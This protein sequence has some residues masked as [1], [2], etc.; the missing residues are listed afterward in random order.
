MWDLVSY[1]SKHNLLN[2]EN[3]QDGENNNHSYNHG[4]EGLTHNLQIL[5]LRKQQ[6]KN[7]LLIL[8]ISQ[9]IP[10]L[11]MGD[12]MGRT[13]LGNNN[14]YCQDNPTTWIDWDRKRDFEDI[15]LFTKNIIKLRKS[16]SIFKKEISLIEGVEIILHGIKLY[17]PDLSY[18][19]LSIAFQLKDIET[20]TDFY[21]AL[22]SYSEKL[23]FEL[24][25]LKNKSW[26]LLTDTSKVDSC[27]F[28]GIKWNDSSYCVLSKSSVIFISK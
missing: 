26:Y 20:D 11:L 18:H 1:N 14:A 12:E 28:E 6:I 15:F 5:S 23:C 24:P 3:N 27:Y 2:G 7:M 19:S 13:Q 17:Q 16:Y 10:M 8:Y 4:E 22:N 25:K 21:I 9:G